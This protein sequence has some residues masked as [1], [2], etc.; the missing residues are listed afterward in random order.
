MLLKYPA[1]KGQIFKTYINVIEKKENK[2][3][4]F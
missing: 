4:E 2:T 3:L 1:L